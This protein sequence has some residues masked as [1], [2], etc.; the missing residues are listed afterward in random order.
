MTDQPQPPL[1]RTR[2]IGRRPA[3]ITATALAVIIAAIAAVIGLAH[4]SRS[5]AGQDK[6]TASATNG[7]ATYRQA[8]L[9]FTGLRGAGGVAVD[10][11]G[12]AYVTDLFNHRVVKL[13]AGTGSQTV[14]PFTDLKGPA[15]VAVDAGGSVYVTDYD[16]LALDHLNSRVVKLA[17]GTNT[18]TELPF[19]DLTHPEGV[20]VDAAGNVYVIDGDLDGNYRVIK[21]NAGTNTQTELPFTD[22]KHSEG[23]AVDAAGNVYVTDYEIAIHRNDN[24]RVVKLAAGTSTQT[25]LPFT[26]LQ[27]PVGVAVDTAGNVYVTDHDIDY[28]SP[29]HVV[30][31]RVVKLSVSTGT[32][33]ALPFTDLKTPLGV[34]VD[35][36]GNV[37]VANEDG[38]RIGNDRVVKLM[39]E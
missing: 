8:A 2:R 30:N 25:E 3:V 20:A 38:T 35:A 28:S 22:L 24:S 11:A 33:T 6:P 13:T 4:P 16:P 9:P 31:S 14:L 18:Q 23:V 5:A 37:Y 17:A 12:N 34:A 19:T 7:P 36:A 27:R 21:L 1:R 26:G 10:E 15:G 39:A 32:Q 29:L